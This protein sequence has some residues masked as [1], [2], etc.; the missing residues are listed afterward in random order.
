MVEPIL[1]PKYWAKRLDEAP[2]T[3]PHHAIMICDI[4][5]WNRI[6]KQHREVLANVISPKMSVVDIGCGWG[7]LLELMPSDW[8]GDYLGIDH[9]P[10]FVEMAREKHNRSFVVSNI[11]EGGSSFPIFDIAVCLSIQLM[12]IENLGV[13][14]WNKLYVRLKTLAKKILILEYEE[15]DTGVLL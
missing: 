15:N 9:C 1:N 2:D 12:V 3:N 10:E 8:T 14:A 11:F 5:E 4:D 6:A 13:V 7:R